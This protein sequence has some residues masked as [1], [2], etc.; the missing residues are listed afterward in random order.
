MA[1]LKQ[2]ERKKGSILRW[3]THL[4]GGV[5]AGMLVG[6]APAGIAVAGVSA[7][8]PDIDTFNSKVGRVSPFLSIPIR[9]IFGHRGVF[10]SLLAAGLIYL[11]AKTL[12]PGYALY[13]FLGYLSHLVLDALTPQGVKFLWPI[14]YSFRIPLVPTGSIFE[15]AFFLLLVVL[16]VGRGF[17]Y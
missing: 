1:L 9:I 15:G 2:G 6:A 3:Q 14:P 7:L 17:L 8:L 16:I 5:L 4:A 10:H 13:V 11:A 12:V